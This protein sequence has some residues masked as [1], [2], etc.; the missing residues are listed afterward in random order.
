MIQDPWAGCTK[1]T[2]FVFANEPTDDELISDLVDE[3]VSDADHDSNGSPD[4]VAVT[5]EL[6]VDDEVE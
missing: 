6:L 5:D 2:E 4:A 3:V 1:K